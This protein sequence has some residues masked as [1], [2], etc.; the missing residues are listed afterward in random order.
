MQVP[1]ESPS[2]FA[3]LLRVATGADMRGNV[4]DAANKIFHECEPILLVWAR[5]E[6]AA[7]NLAFDPQDLIQE[8][9]LR[10]IQQLPAFRGETKAQY[11]AC[12]K[13]ILTRCASGLQQKAALEKPVS[14]DDSKR[15]IKDALPGAEETPSKKVARTET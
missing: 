5:T 12:L 9:V 2:E 4:I 3:E 7:R 1:Q 14:I 8:T 15:G 6:T 11:L 10:A 13:K